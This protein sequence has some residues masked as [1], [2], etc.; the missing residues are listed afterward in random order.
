MIH[1][2]MLKGLN[3]QINAELYSAYLYL[4]MSAHFETVNFRGFAHWLKIQ[5]Q[6]ELGHAMRFY[7][8]IV[9]IGEKVVLEKVETPPVKWASPLA[10]FTDAYKH[11]IEVTGMIN[12]LVNMSASLKDHA[13]NNMLQWF[14]SEQVE[15]ESQTNEIVQKLKFIGDAKGGL[16]ILDHHLAKRKS[17]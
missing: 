16:L 17:E 13:T 7:G 2:K 15:E 6:E 4:A 14:V 5:A 3:K 11:E 1:E 9:E 8:Y 10:S 12:E